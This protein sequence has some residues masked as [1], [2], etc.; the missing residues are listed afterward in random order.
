MER[1]TQ[2]LALDHV[3][4]H[5]EE[6]EMAV[7]GSV[8]LSAK[9]ADEVIDI[10]R[11]TDFY[12]PAHQTLFGVI[13]DLYGRR[14]A[15]DMITVQNELEE[16]GQLAEIGGFGYLF[17][18]TD[19]T[20][21]AQ[22]A[23]HYAEIV[24]EK[25]KL[26]KMLEASGEIRQLV[27]DTALAFRDKL[28]RAEELIYGIRSSS[29]TGGFRSL[30]DH[31]TEFFSHIEP[32]LQGGQMVAGLETGY[33]D[34]DAMTT[35]FSEGDLIIVAARPAMGK[36]SL[37]LNVGLNVARMKKQPVA[38]FS[39]EMSGEQLVRR[40][41][42]TL[43]GVSLSA[44]RK[45]GLDTRD[46]DKLIA[47]AEV[48][49]QAPMHI[50]DSS[51]ISPTDMLAKL[52]RFS[53]RYGPPALVIVD[54]LQLMRSSRRTD[55][56]TQEVSEIA[57]GLKELA[58]EMKVPV[59]ALSQLSREV[60]KRP[61][62]RPQLADLRESGSIE[63]EAD[64]VMFIYRQKYYDDKKNPSIQ[65]EQNADEAQ[66]A[67]IIIGKHRNGPTGTVLLGFQPSY[68]RFTLLDEYSKTEYL[69]SIKNR[70]VLE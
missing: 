10:V 36:T 52:R 66:V 41:I 49:F 31:G 39:L 9:A 51:G 7:L 2:D 5:S 24:V 58:R 20:P 62:N 60:E 48:L 18:L 53:S 11:R 69:N 26:R 32:L 67:E 64:M 15:V 70:E 47:S 14:R 44:M 54:Y 65:Q 55:N 17:R 19:S 37:V 56:R 16:R 40:L 34:L 22:A 68:T 63:A 1:L 8:M 33:R 25:H 57:R 46:Y 29:T 21:S 42:S 3:P 4:P 27:G 30:E 61:N 43:S 35:G 59:M 6:A 23:R 13:E 28:S 45:S 12:F 38:V 50:D